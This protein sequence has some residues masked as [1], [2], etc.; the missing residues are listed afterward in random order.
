MI[1]YRQNIDASLLNTNNNVL[2]FRE[3]QPVDYIKI[4]NQS[5]RL[6]LWSYTIG[7][8]EVRWSPEV[9]EIYGLEPS[10]KP[11]NLKRAMQFYEPEDAKKLAELVQQAIALR[12]GFQ[13]KLRLRRA[14]GVYRVVE[15]N[16]AP[17]LDESGRV[18]RLT[19]TFRDIT[20]QTEYENV[21]KG[22]Q[23]LLVRTIRCLPM[24]AALLDRNYRYVAWSER[25][26]SDL[27]VD[28]AAQYVGRD[29]REALPDLFRLQ[30]NHLDMALRGLPV[31]KDNER[32]ERDSG[33]VYITDWRLQ[34]WRGKTGDVDGVLVL[35]QVKYTAAPRLEPHASRPDLLAIDV[36][37]PLQ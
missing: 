17:V 28:E 10:P 26:I 16:A 8:D 2:S 31:G 25:W 24:A 9:Y 29:H 32:F 36:H 3:G 7:S 11:L 19:G 15:S 30:Q 18:T 35:M 27:K 4:F 14:D 13:C 20:T 23:E 12:C 22:H 37:H 21:R 1:A 5:H 34:P 6:G 33:V